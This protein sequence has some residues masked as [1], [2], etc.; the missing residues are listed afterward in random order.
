M[1]Y[2]SGDLIDLSP[3][4]SPAIGVWP[5]DT[6]MSREVL[7][8]LAD[9]ASV[10]LSTLHATVHLGTHTDAWS[11]AVD[12]EATIEAMPLDA[13]VGPCQLVHV[14]IGR[15]ELITPAHLPDHLEAPRLLVGT[16][17]FPDPD[18][19]TTDFAAFDPATAEWLADQGGLLLG[20]DTPSVDVFDSKELPTHHT[21]V[22]RRLAILEGLVVAGV[23]DGVYELMALPLPLAGFDASPVRAVLRVP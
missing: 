13:Y 21:C 18:D 16:G 3:L 5:G 8:T 9:G 6:P 4:A 14:D 15:N 7:A 19:F 23:P 17:T 2:S 10:E 12:G 20:I 11:H 22:S 1:R